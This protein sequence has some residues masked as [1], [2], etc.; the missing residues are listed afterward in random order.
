MFVYVCMYVH[1]C[2]CMCARYRVAQSKRGGTEG[3]EGEGLGGGGQKREKR[4]GDGRQ[5][6][7]R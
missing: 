2:T 3:R 6:M 7:L 5:M 1:V 4:G